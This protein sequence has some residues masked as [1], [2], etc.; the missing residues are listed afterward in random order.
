[1]ADNL[2]W[3]GPSRCDV[4]NSSG[5]NAEHPPLIYSL[6]NG[7]LNHEFGSVILIS[8]GINGAIGEELYQ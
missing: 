4:S 6:E 8:L 2:L 1:M 7:A 3:K 5:R